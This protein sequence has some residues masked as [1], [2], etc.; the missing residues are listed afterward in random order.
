MNIKPQEGQTVQPVFT[1]DATLTVCGHPVRLDP[2]HMEAD[3]IEGCARDLRVNRDGLREM[4]SKLGAV[5]LKVHSISEGPL[6]LPSRADQQDDPRRVIG[7]L[8]ATAIMG[9][10]AS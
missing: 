8:L 2:F 10:L 6:T 7:A 3:T 1:I 9:Y 4:L 5:D